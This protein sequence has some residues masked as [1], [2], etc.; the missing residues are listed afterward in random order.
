MLEIWRLYV[1]FIFTHFMLEGFVKLFDYLGRSCI[2]CSYFYLFF[3][4]FFLFWLFFVKFELMGLL[5]IK[6]FSTN[7]AKAWFLAIVIKDYRS[8]IFIVFY[9]WVLFFFIYSL[10]FYF[11]VKRIVL[12]NPFLL[13]LIISFCFDVLEN[14]T[15]FLKRWLWLILRLEVSI[16]A[17]TL[18]PVMFIGFRA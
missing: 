6:N 13:L 12:S 14:T 10:L 7:W 1:L 2:C 8:V 4:L 16:E 15:Y 11:L 17:V 3:K 5:I 18:F 9:I